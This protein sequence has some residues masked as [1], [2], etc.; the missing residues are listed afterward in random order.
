MFE[1]FLWYCIG[2]HC[3]RVILSYSFLPIWPCIIVRLSWRVLSTAFD[4]SRMLVA[5][6]LSCRR[7]GNLSNSSL[8]MAL[9]SLS[10]RS[11][12]SLRGLD[13]SASCGQWLNCDSRR[14]TWA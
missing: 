2:S 8:G 4:D 9:A 13:S 6:S 1:Q 3:C 7:D 5:I 10:M 11:M 14:W 12:G